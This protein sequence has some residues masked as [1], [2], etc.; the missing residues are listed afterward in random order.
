MPEYVIGMAFS[1][2][3]GIIGFG[4]GKLSKLDQRIDDLAVKVAETY[5][6]KDDID[7]LENKLDAAILYRHLQNNPQVGPCINETHNLL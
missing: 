1:A 3:L 4:A 7:R 6:T 5:V 2:A